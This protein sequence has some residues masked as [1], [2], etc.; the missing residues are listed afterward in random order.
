MSDLSLTLVLQL[1]QVKIIHD[2]AK[3]SIKF[4]NNT[5]FVGI[6]HVRELFSRYVDF[7]STKCRDSIVMFIHICVFLFAIKVRLL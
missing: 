6:F 4:E 2:M 7:L 5:P 1:K 3:V